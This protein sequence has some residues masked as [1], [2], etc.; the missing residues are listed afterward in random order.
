MTKKRIF[1][2]G[3]NTGKDRL[4]CLILSSQ[5]EHKNHFNFP[6]SGLTHLTINEEKLQ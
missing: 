5:S 4:Q 3:T 6:T 2:C 1:P